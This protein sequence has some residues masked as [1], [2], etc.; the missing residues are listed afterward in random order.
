MTRFEGPK[1]ECWIYR[2]NVVKQIAFIKIAPISRLFRDGN[3]RMVFDRLTI[4]G[5]GNYSVM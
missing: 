3:E 2:K 5:F 4:R 1:T